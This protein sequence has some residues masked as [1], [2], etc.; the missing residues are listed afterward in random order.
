MKKLEANPKVWQFYLNKN[1]EKKQEEDNNSILQYNK[2]LIL[3][4]CGKVK[5]SN[6]ILK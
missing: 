2:A 5:Q 4:L 6:Q 1:V 3:Y